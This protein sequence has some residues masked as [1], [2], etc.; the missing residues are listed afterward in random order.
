[1]ELL[2]CDKRSSP[3]SLLQVHKRHVWQ[4]HARVRTDTHMFVFLMVVCKLW[5]ILRN[6]SIS[7]S[8]IHSFWMIQPTYSPLVLILFSLWFILKDH[9]KI[10]IRRRFFHGLPSVWKFLIGLFLLSLWNPINS[11]CLIHAYGDII[12]DWYWEKVM[13]WSLA[14]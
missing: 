1:M 9:L 4:T 8:N 6:I 11:L 2:H 5:W 12:L 10:L 7:Q 14:L 3:F 13:V